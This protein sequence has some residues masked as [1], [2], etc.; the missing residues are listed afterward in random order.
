MNRP[1]AVLI[2]SCFCLFAALSGCKTPNLEPGGSYTTTNAVGEV[3]S[4]DKGLFMADSA[5]K[6]AYDA[7][8]A[9]FR[10]ERDNRKTLW[11]ISPSIKGSMDKARGEVKHIEIRWATARKAYRSSPTPEGL[12][13]MEK[14]LA[15]LQKVLTVVQSQVSPIK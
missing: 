12:N 11:D 7:V 15:E 3:V 6:L 14:I 9:A 13:T 8:D 2:F 4:M 10:F 5:Y 1:L